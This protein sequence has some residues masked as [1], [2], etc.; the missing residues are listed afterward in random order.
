MVFFDLFFSSFFPAIF[1]SYPWLWLSSH[2]QKGNPCIQKLYYYQPS[3]LFCSILSAERHDV[4]AVRSAYFSSSACNAIAAAYRSEDESNRQFGPFSSCIN[5]N[6]I[7][8]L[9]C[10]KTDVLPTHI[11]LAGFISKVSNQTSGGEPSEFLQRPSRRVQLSLSELS[12]L[13]FRSPTRYRLSS[14][15][16]NNFPDSVILFCWFIRNIAGGT[17]IDFY[18][19]N[20]NHSFSGIYYSTMSVADLLPT[21]QD[22]FVNQSHIVKGCTDIV[23]S[24]TKSTYY[25]TF[26]KI[27]FVLWHSGKFRAGYLM[28]IRKTLKKVS[29]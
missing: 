11:R 29:S 13:R 8:A 21:E 24:D 18:M 26:L 28:V 22:T 23:H 16:H 25:E 3:C 9:Q 12:G 2:I 14:L 17:F 7:S 15:R 27:I 10:G 19:S 4:D 20:R 5:D 6:D 1:A